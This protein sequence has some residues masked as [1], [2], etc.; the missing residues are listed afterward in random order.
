MEVKGQPRVSRAYSHVIF[1]LSSIL[2]LEFTM[3]S[4][5]APELPCA[6]FS[7]FKVRE[8]EL[9]LP[10]ETRWACSHPQLAVLTPFLN[11]PHHR[12]SYCPA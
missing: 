10:A 6:E 7:E 12:L 9:F 1:S 3:G 5:A 2:V 4:E 11:G 8:K